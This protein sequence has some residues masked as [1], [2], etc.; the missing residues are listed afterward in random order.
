MTEP[1]D[2]RTLEGIRA[3]VEGELADAIVHCVAQHGDVPPIG[4]VIA[5]MDADGNALDPPQPSIWGG[6]SNTPE[7]VRTLLRDNAQKLGG[8]GVVH[9]QQV[10]RQVI[11]RL[12]HRDHGDHVWRGV[13][14][15]GRFKGLGRMMEAEP[16][17]QSRFMP[18][19]W[20][21]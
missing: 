17:E 21:N 9:I 5:T 3:Y 11:V 14:D 4:V 7:R 12:E 16:G 18:E 8:A 1:R 6:G 2:L 15:C 19:R 13:V 10:D 20:A